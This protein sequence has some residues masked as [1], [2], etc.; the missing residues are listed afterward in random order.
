MQRLSPATRT[1]T[2]RK[3]LVR[4]SIGTRKSE[5]T[6]NPA[7][8]DTRP[9]N[10]ATSARANAP[11][12][13]RRRSANKHRAPTTTKT[14]DRDL[15]DPNT[16]P[17]PSAPRH[18]RTLART[19]EHAPRRRNNPIRAPAQTLARTGE[20]APPTN[21]HHTT[22]LDRPTQKKKK[23]HASLAPIAKTASPRGRLRSV[24]LAL[25][26]SPRLFHERP[27]QLRQRAGVARGKSSTVSLQKIA[28]P[29]TFSLRTVRRTS[30]RAP[31][32]TNGDTKRHW[33]RGPPMTRKG[34]RLRSRASP[35]RRAGPSPPANSTLFSLP[36]HHLT[37]APNKPD[38]SLGNAPT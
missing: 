26:Q 22:R 4:H 30:F 17:N 13:R 1:A 18:A 14:R 9:I 28:P 32:A 15:H 23:Q 12:H 21:Y 3:H 6:R 31:D 34:P 10:N 29:R 2:P 38:P 27:P 16:A 5:P 8:P 11:S 36:A 20:H 37:I 35:Y 33:L 19:G 25:H 24:G 7:K